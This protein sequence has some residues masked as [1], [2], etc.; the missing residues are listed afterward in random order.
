MLSWSINGYNYIHCTNFHI[1][2]D[3]I[4]IKLSPLYFLWE[5]TAPIN[6]AARILPF[7]LNSK[8]LKFHKKYPCQSLSFSLCLVP[9][10]SLKWIEIDNHQATEE[11][12]KRITKKIFHCYLQIVKNRLF[13]Y[14]QLDWVLAEET[15]SIRL[16]VP[17]M[18]GYDFQKFHEFSLPNLR[19][20][21]L[22]W[23]RWWF[24]RNKMLK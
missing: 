22:L 5:R 1:K 18:D 11:E 19:S 10:L 13:V 7:L 23:G 20:I 3:I 6:Y 24:A 8:V 14:F 16:L 4:P 2:Q 21:Q 9:F 17:N 12:T 15:T